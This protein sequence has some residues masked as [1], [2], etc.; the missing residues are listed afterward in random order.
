[1]GKITAPGAELPRAVTVLQEGCAA[2]L[3]FNRSELLL[4]HSFGMC[5]PP[6]YA[7]FGGTEP[8][9]PMPG[10]LYQRSIALRAAIHAYSFHRFGRFLSARVSLAIGLDRIDRQA[11]RLGDLTVTGAGC[12]ALGNAFFLLLSHAFSPIQKAYWDLPPGDK[13]KMPGIRTPAAQ[14]ITLQYRSK[15]RL[16]VATSQRVCYNDNG[17]E[18]D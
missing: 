14:K 18:Y 15:F 12:P 8:F 9:L 1:M 2:M 4:D 7:A 6:S 10:S 17:D 11:E 13:R 5:F 16:Y 3:A